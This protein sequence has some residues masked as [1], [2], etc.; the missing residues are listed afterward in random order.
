LQLTAYRNYFQQLSYFDFQGN[1]IAYFDSGEGPVIFLL[2][3]VPTSSW[4]YR[5]IAP[6]LVNAGYRVI[7]PDML[8][9]GAS[10]KPQELDSYEISQM[11]KLIHHLTNFLKIETWSHVFHDAGGLWT[12][13]MLQLDS[14]KVRH[15]FMLNTIVY[16]EG[17][18]PPIKFKEGLIA[19]KYTEQYSSKIGQKIVLDNTFRNGIK[20]RDVIDNEMLEGYRSPLINNYSAGLY[21]FFT[22]TCQ[23]IPDYTQLHKSLN[24][25]TTVIWGSKDNMLVWKNIEEQVQA[26]FDKNLVDVQLIEAKHFIQE[27]QPE[28][29]AE[30]IL[31]TLKQ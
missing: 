5:K 26:N 9:F 15:L 25:P 17:F 16:K 18:K 4:L 10:D 24:I 20:N 30:V 14:S 11:G 27:E 12:W 21:Y 6:L 23:G 3:G 2:H 31:K 13:E 28:M 29:I 19:K 1:R 7:A 22:R 8:G